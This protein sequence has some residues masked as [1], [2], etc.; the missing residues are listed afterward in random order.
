MANGVYDERP[1]TLPQEKTKRGSG[2]GSLIFVSLM[3]IA[4]CLWRILTPGGEWPLPPVHY[5]QMTFDAGML[6]CLVAAVAWPR[7][8]SGDTPARSDGVTILLLCGIAAGII[9]LLIRFTNKAAW[10]T[11]HLTNAWG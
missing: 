3:L 10:W 4:Q 9:L 2:Q 6:V 5:M 1:A 11:G 7:Q 8:T